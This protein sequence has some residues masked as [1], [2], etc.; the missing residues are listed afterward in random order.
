MLT[1]SSALPFQVWVQRCGCYPCRGHPYPCT[2]TG[3]FWRQEHL[4]SPEAS[5]W[6]LR[7]QWGIHTDALRH[8]CGTS[9]GSQLAL[10]RGH[11]SLRDT[12][13]TWAVD[14]ALDASGTGGW[15]PTE[16][17]SAVQ[18]LRSPA[19]PFNTTPSSPRLAAPPGTDSG[20]PSEAFL[21]RQEITSLSRLPFWAPGPRTHLRE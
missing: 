17:T 15:Q 3:W 12:V 18:F 19:S 5:R 2:A 20:D 13:W 21:G 7:P 10:Q 14:P 11:S 16:R 6:F 4:P 8:R 1:S 9:W